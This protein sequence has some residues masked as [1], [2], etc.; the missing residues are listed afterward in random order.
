MP[1]LTIQEL[2]HR[3]LIVSGLIATFVVAASLVL[4]LSTPALA[5]N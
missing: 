1:P 5:G 2:G 3:L 4:W